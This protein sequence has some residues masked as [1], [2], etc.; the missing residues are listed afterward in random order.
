MYLGKVV[1]DRGVLGFG[2]LLEQPRRVWGIEFF[3]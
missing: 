3:E 2:L 1:L